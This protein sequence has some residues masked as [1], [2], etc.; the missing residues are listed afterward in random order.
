MLTP[1]QALGITGFVTLILPAQWLAKIMYLVLG[2][3]FWHVPPI[4]VALPAGDHRR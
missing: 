1:A 2:L 4:L 3:A